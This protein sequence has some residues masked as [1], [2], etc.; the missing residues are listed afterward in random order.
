MF[1]GDVI[2]Q[3]I[4]LGVM[5]LILF[6]VV[7]SFRSFQRQKEM[8]DRLKRIEEKVETFTEENKTK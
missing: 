6:F 4:V 3:L 1:I 2:W 8:N 7:S 5:A